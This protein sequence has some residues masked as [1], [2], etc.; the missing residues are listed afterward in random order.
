[1][2]TK[3]FKALTPVGE[4]PMM[5]YSPTT[6]KTG[7]CMVAFHGK[8]EA[9]NGTLTGIDKVTGNFSELLKRVDTYGFS[10]LAPQVSTNLTGGNL[11]WSD[12]HIEAIIDYAVANHT[13]LGKVAVTGLS[14]GAGTV[15]EALTN[16]KTAPKIFG[17]IAICPTS[18]YGDNLANKNDFALIAK[19]KIAVWDFHAVDDTTCYPANSRNMIAKAKGFNPRPDVTYIEYPTGGHYIWGRAWATE[20]IYP[21]LFSFAPTATQ[22][23]PTETVDEILSTYKLTNYKSGKT[24]LEKI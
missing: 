18:Q 16:E 1:M 10:V 7:V 8:G 9:G 14:Q 17:A 11:W 21:A 22:P 4:I 3:N 2:T 15:W 6:D 24:T 13:K 19:Y 20:E 12:P 23:P 5:L